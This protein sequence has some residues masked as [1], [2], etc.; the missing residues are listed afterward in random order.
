MRIPPAVWDAAV[1]SRNRPP[2]SL[3]QSALRSPLAFSPTQGLITSFSRHGGV[4]KQC[5]GRG[6][7]PD[8]SPPR[9]SPSVRSRYA[10]RTQ[11]SRR[12]NGC[13]LLGDGGVTVTNQEVSSDTESDD[14]GREKNLL[15]CR[16]RHGGLSFE[17]ELVEIRLRLRMIRIDGECAPVMY[18]CALVV[19]KPGIGEPEVVVQVGRIGLNQ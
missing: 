2:P 7:R 17:S 3:R 5:R 14:P 10:V 15:G 9:C 11:R 6:G 13:V 4:G 18:G 8:H 16:S 1:T 19:A 12:R